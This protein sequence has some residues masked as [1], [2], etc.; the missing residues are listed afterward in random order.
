VEEERSTIAKSESGDTSCGMTLGNIVNGG[1]G[2]AT[3]CWISAVSRLR[4]E[5]SYASAVIDRVVNARSAD[6]STGAPLSTSTRKQPQVEVRT[7]VATTALSVSERTVLI[8][9]DSHPDW[10]VDE[11]NVF[12][13]GVY[14]FSSLLGCLLA[15]GGLWPCGCSGVWVHKQR[16]T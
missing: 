6:E 13:F 12:F 16:T 1:G 4:L 9:P 10:P 5:F 15:C 8:D 2:Q 7:R 11:R 14:I 3:A